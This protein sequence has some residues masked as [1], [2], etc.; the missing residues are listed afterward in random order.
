[1]REGDVVLRRGVEFA[2]VGNLGGEACGWRG[3]LVFATWVRV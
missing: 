2:G 3:F 1:M